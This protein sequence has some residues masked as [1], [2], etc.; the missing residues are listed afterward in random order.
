VGGVSVGEPKEKVLEVLDWTLS[1]LPDDRPRY[2]MGVGTPLDILE[3]VERGA[4][5]FDCV[6]PT[7]LGR[8]GSAYTTYGRINLKNARFSEDWGPIDPECSCAACRRYSA[9]YIRHLYRSN[10]ILSARLLTLHNLHFYANLMTQ[11]REAIMQDRFPEFKEAFLEKYGRTNG[12][13][14][15]PSREDFQTNET[16]DLGASEPA[17]SA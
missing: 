10:E 3:A 7:R 12:D 13:E 4:D 14:V 15:G 9:A 16:D 5:M 11:I 6:L 8:N 1:V 17:E 2:I